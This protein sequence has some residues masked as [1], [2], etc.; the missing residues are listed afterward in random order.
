MGNLSKIVAKPCNRK[1][2]KVMGFMLVVLAFSWSGILDLF[3]LSSIDGAILDAGI[4]YGLARAINSAVSV[5]QTLEVSVVVANISIGEALD[6]INDLIERFS[7]VMTYALGSLAIQ[8]VMMVLVSDKVFNV[9]LTASFGMFAVA[10]AFAK[11]HMPLALKVFALMAFIRVSF[12]VVVLLN[13]AVDAAFIKPQEVKYADQ[14]KTL[15]S[16][17]SKGVENLQSAEADLQS[18][19]HQ[20]EQV[21]A[22]LRSEESGLLVRITEL[23]DDLAMKEQRLDAMG[24]SEGVFDRLTR[25]RSAQEQ[26]LV[27][28]IEAV[29]GSIS[30]LQGRLELNTDKQETVQEEVSCIRKRAD[31]GTC[32]VGEWLESK[33]SLPNIK[34]KVDA[35]LESMGDAVES[36]IFLMAIMIL[37]S[38]AIPLAFWLVLYKGM[39]S[40]WNYDFSKVSS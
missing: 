35:V 4:L 5:L 27:D 38:I 36:F 12:A 28:E 8:K 25:K 40:I 10:Y 23:R 13:S 7:E 39:K 11:D 24:A 15:E 6:P 14:V 16:S 32:S 21:L 26:K 19:I 9:L 2:L 33:V 1:S 17:I 22:D 18:A 30:A 29:E 31:G 37:K 20:E 3:A 34:S